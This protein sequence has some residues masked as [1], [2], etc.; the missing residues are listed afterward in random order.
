LAC[1]RS[2]THFDNTILSIMSCCDMSCLQ[3]LI[4]YPAVMKLVVMITLLLS[5]ADV[6][7]TFASYQPYLDEEFVIAPA[8]VS[9]FTGVYLLGTYIGNKQKEK[10]TKKLIHNIETGMY[11]FQDGRVISIDDVSGFGT[12]EH[13]FRKFMVT[14][15]LGEKFY[16]ERSNFIRNVVKWKHSVPFFRLARFGWMADIPAGDFAGILN[17]NA[18]YSFTI[19]MSQLGCSLFFIFSLK[20]QSMIIWASLAISVG[21]LVL[22]I[23]NIVVS[24]P[25][26]LNQLEK[27]NAN[28][29]QR[30][31][32][33]ENTVMPHIL[34]MRT[35]CEA[36]VKPL[37]GRADKNDEILVIMKKYAEAEQHFMQK[38]QDIE[39]QKH[40]RGYSGGGGP[41]IG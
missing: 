25:K 16:A 36:E 14:N 23:M 13:Q 7:F 41:T 34:G 40:D 1:F 10:F 33:F 19:G 26:V 38:M 15:G 30:K 31:K 11:H 32:A 21:S 39:N 27:D 3:A 2:N 9:L 4:K 35:Q 17:S 22:S 29:E 8:L 6:F 28:E 24:F 20:Q 37:R 12:T 5:D 18:L